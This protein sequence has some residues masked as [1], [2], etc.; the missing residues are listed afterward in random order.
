MSLKV[1]LVRFISSSFSLAIF[2]P[3][4]TFDFYMKNFLIFEL[5]YFLI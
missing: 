3:I 5:Q 4:V 1:K 2:V